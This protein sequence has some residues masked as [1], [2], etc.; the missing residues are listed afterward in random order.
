MLPDPV[1]SNPQPDHQLDAH[2]TEPLGLATFSTD[3]TEVLI[4][5]TH[6]FKNSV[7]FFK[8]D[9]VDGT[10]DQDETKLKDKSNQKQSN[11]V[12]QENPSQPSSGGPSVKC[13]LA[14]HPSF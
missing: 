3:V 2:L 7:V 10:E 8:D 5:K 6:W 13:K 11:S 9:A 1:G 4:T 12:P 14:P